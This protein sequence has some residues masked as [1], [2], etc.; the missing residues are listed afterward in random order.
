[1]VLFEEMEI[2]GIRKI[3]FS[4]SATVYDSSNPIPFSECGKL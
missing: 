2:A 4:S 3:I 1:M